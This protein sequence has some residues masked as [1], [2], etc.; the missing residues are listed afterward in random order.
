MVLRRVELLLDL[1][2]FV[3]CFKKH[4]GTALTITERKIAV[5]GRNRLM[6]RLLK[7]LNRWWDTEALQRY[8]KFRHK[9]IANWLCVRGIGKDDLSKTATLRCTYLGGWILSEMWDSEGRASCLHPQ[10]SVWL[11][12]G[13]IIF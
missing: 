8:F 2:F 12:K 13:G 10:S 7:W 4:K 5:K 3:H 1:L 6:A 9:R 11:Y